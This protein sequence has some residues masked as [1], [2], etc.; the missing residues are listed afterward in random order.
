MSTRANIIITDGTDKIIFYRHSD[1]YPEGTLPTLNVFMDWRRAGKIRNNVMQAA[2]WLTII[3][4]LEY[5]TIPQ[6][7]RHEPA[8]KGGTAYA[9]LSTIE[10][11]KDWK[12][13]SYEITT[14]IHGDIDF[15]YIIDLKQQTIKCFEEWD[16]N[17][18]GRVEVEI[19]KELQ[20]K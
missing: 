14:G 2:S 15:L 8:F 17:G 5:D 13:S 19:P 7:Q 6:C 1:G 10:P 16:E 4:A 20:I 11:P 18:R 3:G 9:D 12:A